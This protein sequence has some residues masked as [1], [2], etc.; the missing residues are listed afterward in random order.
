MAWCVVRGAGLYVLRTTTDP[1]ISSEHPTSSSQPL[2][3]IVGPTAVGKTSLSLSLAQH[4]QAEIISA[5]SRQIYR[6]CDI[7]TA[8]ATPAEQAFV[9]HFMLDVVDPDQILTLAEFQEQVYQ[10][11]AAI[12]ARGNL[13]MLVGGS[14]QWVKAVVEGWGIPKVLPD[15]ALRAELEQTVEEEGYQAL[16]DQLAQVDPPAAEKID[17]RNVRRVVR[18]LEVYLKTGTPIS[19]HQRK[20]PPPYTIIQIGLTRSRETLYQRVDQRID[21]M[22]VE[23][24][25]DEV[26]QLIHM[27]YDWKLPAMSGLGYRQIGQYLRGEESLET[28]VMLIKRETRRFV[29]QQY[30]WFRLDDSAIKWFDGDSC[31]SEEIRRYVASQLKPVR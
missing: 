27:G 13:P 16:H 9:P 25:L 2:L 14:G 10:L 29:R 31:S 1:I 28:A 22:M 6:G 12:H 26:Q 24:L 17:A 18:A 23:G 5:D 21:Q 15:Q 19:Q 4:F 7:G 3:V 8:K 30:N 20:S 11:V